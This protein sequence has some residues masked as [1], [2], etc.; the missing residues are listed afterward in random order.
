MSES[1]FRSGIRSSVR[2]YWS[3]ALSRSDFIGA[4]TSALKRNL[5]NAWNEGSLDC[6]IDA[7]ELTDDELKARDVFIK[8]QQGYIGGFAD[9]IHDNSKVANGKLQI[10][11]ERAEMWILR[12]GEIRDRAKVLACGDR[13]LEWKINQRCSEHCSSCLSL[14]G[15]VKRASYWKK[16]DIYPRGKML[17]CGGWRCCCEFL[18]TDKPV[19]RGAISI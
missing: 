14:N 8:E 19:S 2:G 18:V 5:A 7:T 17:E 9:A 3:G 1:S 16:A 11:F 15:K 6:G 4:L 12:Y 10:L 13:K